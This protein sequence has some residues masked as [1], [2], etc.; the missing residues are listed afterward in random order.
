MKKKQ[1]YFTLLLLLLLAFM[2]SGQV[3]AKSYENWMQIATD[4]NVHL[5]EAVKSY[6]DG[7]LD[8]AKE[9]I[10]TAYFK[11][12]EKL[13]FEK[14]VK[15]YIS[16]RRVKN[17]EALFHSSKRLSTE[18][19][20]E[21]ELKE[22]LKE[23]KSD[24]LEDAKKLDSS[25]GE[26]SSAQ[27]SKTASSNSVVFISSFGLTLREGLEAILVI[28]A[29]IAY[30]MKTNNKKLVKKVYV[31]SGLGIVFS[32]I[33]A[34]IFSYVSQ[35]LGDV[36]GG[37]SQ[38]L[39][40]GF[41]MF[42][43]VAVLFYMSNWMLSKSS[44][45]NWNEYVSEK[46]QVSVS[47]GSQRALIFS[48]FLA[49]AREGAELILFFQGVQATVKDN[50]QYIWYGLG[51]AILILALVFVLI[52]KFSV[53]LP[54]KPF[55]YGTSILMFIMCFSFLGKGVSE[56][57]EAD[58]FTQTFVP[59]MNGFSFDFLGIYD[60]YE[61]LIPQLILIVITVIIFIKYTKGGKKIEKV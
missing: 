22:T 56:L 43:A 17:I 16:G 58:V 18:S 53:R 32:L 9:D 54:L 52:T 37:K 44:T 60:M 61:S 28:S 38:E 23:L 25:S 7:D 40:E 4:M 36:V 39:F 45:E 50:S 49:V 27:E 15:T 33:L 35:A 31:G 47:K 34:F 19:G 57:Q 14:T 59:W 20:N 11:F 2:P 6:S 8:Q 21:T 13:G 55:F 24:L 42:L 48:A 3:F 51:A 26:N 1:H 30:L 41:T 46:V 10:N 5:D 12:Y 29:I